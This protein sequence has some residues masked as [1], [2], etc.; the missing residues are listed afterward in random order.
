M[1]LA[2]YT[3]SVIYSVNMPN[4]FIKSATKHRHM[5]KKLINHKLKCTFTRNR[6]QTKPKIN[7]R[8]KWNSF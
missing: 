4:I 8:E 7:Q 5:M 6:W 1:S 3:R 2:Q